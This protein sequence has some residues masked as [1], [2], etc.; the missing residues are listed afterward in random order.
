MYIHA[1][2]NGNHTSFLETTNLRNRDILLCNG[3]M[4]CSLCIHCPEVS[5]Y[6][7]KHGIYN[8]ISIKF[9]GVFSNIPH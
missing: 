3:Q 9:Y 2:V 1:A 6:I 7:V 5:L 8:V 4:S